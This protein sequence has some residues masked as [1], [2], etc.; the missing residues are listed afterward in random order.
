MN[1]ATKLSSEQSTPLPMPKRN[2]TR[3]QKI[4]L[5]VLPI[6]VVGGLFLGRSGG[7]PVDAAP[8]PATVTAAAPVV[9]QITE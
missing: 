4:I 9:R 2:L 8:P 1:L 3:S 5:G 6:A 7:S